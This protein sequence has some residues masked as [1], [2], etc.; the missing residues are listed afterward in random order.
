MTNNDVLRRLRYIL[1]IKNTTMIDIFKLSD[2]VFKE[3][4]VIALLKKEEEENYLECTNEDMTAF[5]DGLIVY[6]RGPSNKKAEVDPT[7]LTNNMILK[8]IRIALEIKEEDMLKVLKL[9]GIVISK[10]E[11]S[12]LFRKEGHKNYK[13]CGDQI[14]RN[15]L[16]GLTEKYRAKTNV[17]DEPEEKK[18]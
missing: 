7:H 11:L 10:Y 13:E 2:K 12:A 9:G 4:G 16:R 1:D 8:K 3:D 6:K 15:F 5:L 17:K 14:L 18:P